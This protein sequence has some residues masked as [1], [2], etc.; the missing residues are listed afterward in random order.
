MEETSFHLTSEI[1]LLIHLCKWGICYLEDTQEHFIKLK[2]N[3]ED[4]RVVGENNLHFP[5]L[6]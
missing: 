1:V 5:F 3:R 6:S 2:L 4:R